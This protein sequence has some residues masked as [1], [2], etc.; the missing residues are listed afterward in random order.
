MRN[1]DIVILLSAFLSFLLSVYLW[2]SGEKEMGQYVSI[3]VPT[4]IVFGVFFN[5]LPRK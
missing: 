4:I 2:F 5:S 1:R 3:W